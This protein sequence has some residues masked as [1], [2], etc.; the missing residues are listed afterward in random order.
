[1]KINVSKNELE[2]ILNCAQ[3][4]LLDM[5]LKGQKLN[6]KGFGTFFI[7]EKCER[8]YYDIRLNKVC[9]VPPKKVIV[10]KCNKKLI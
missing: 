2:T 6:I 7:K 10:F 3:D 4:L 5:L 8:K 9:F 1:M